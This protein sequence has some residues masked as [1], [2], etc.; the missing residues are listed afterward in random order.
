[1]PHGIAKGTL[2]SDG[3]SCLS[4]CRPNTKYFVLFF[5]LSLCLHFDNFNIWYDF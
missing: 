3:A 2:H 1:M 4:F 5:S